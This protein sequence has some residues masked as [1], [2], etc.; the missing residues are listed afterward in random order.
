MRK[1]PRNTRIELVTFAVLKRRDNHYTNRALGSGVK[2]KIIIA[3]K[4]WQT[5][6]H[7][8]YTVFL[9]RWPRLSV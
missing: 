1:R 8:V 5:D 2:Y 7:V 4:L 3:F 9:L 6:L